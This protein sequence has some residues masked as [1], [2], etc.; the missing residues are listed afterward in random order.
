MI[1]SD[2]V[3][4]KS[5]W[6]YISQA[7]K[8]NRL[9]HALLLHGPIGNCKEGFAIEVAALMN[10]KS[11]SNDNGACGKCSSC[12]KVISFQH[13]NILLIHP[14]PSSDKSV[15]KDGGLFH[16]LTNSSLLQ[17]R[18]MLEKKGID[19]Y[20]TIELNASTIP[21]KIIRE[22][23]KDLY[24]SSVESGWRIV[25]IFK[26]E[27]LCTGE[28][29]SAN[30]ILKI[31]E[32]PPNNTLFILIADKKEMLLDTI[33]SRCQG[34]YF[35][36]V[37]NAMMVALLEERGIA[38]DRVQLL[39]RI[40]FG[41]IEKALVLNEHFQQIQNDV[42]IILKAIFSE[43][44]E[45]WKNYQYRIIDLKRSGLLTIFNC[46]FL[47]HSIIFKDLLLMQ[48]MKKTSELIFIKFQE[49]YIKILEKYPNSDFHSCI[50]II[51]SAL[52]DFDSN[53]N[54]SFNALN[55]LLDIRSALKGVEVHSILNEADYY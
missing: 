35:P 13:P 6:K 48:K 1:Y 28:M 33:L 29:A 55:I 2:L 53:V 31:L 40:C 17:M 22:C 42:K 38:N 36:V 47:L 19:P 12:L 30:A 27:F 52:I 51:E 20:A 3:I 34:L 9:P 16:N 10:C 4:P 23:R 14:M 43:N 37:D 26:A 46:F 11:P 49:N 21:V 18:E 15:S 25:L 8:N 50:D 39:S 32:E 45:F 7:I 24:M 41:D 54:I 44:P 5:K